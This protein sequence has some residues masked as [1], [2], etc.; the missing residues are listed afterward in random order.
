MTTTK[1]QRYDNG[2]KRGYVYA[3]EVWD[4][5]IHERE[6]FAA[7]IYRDTTAGQIPRQQITQWMGI[8]TYRKSWLSGCMAGVEA[9]LDERKANDW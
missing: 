3:A 7:L 5:E 4:Q 8:H 2:F 6:G 1:Q 9:A